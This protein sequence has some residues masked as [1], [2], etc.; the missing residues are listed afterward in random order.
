MQKPYSWRAALAVFSLALLSA[1]PFGIANAQGYV[2][3]EASVSVDDSELSFESPVVSAE[4][5]AEDESL[6]SAQQLLQKLGVDDSVA[7]SVSYDDNVLTIFAD[8]SIQELVR[9][10]LGSKVG[11]LA[12]QY[13]KSPFS[14]SELT[15]EGQ[16]I[17]SL[18][19]VAWAGP[20]D[21]FSGL[22]V[23]IRDESITRT[24]E[25]LSAYPLTLVP[26]PDPIVPAS[27]DRTG[28]PV[29]GGSLI[30][31]TSSR[32][33]CSSG[34]QIGFTG[35]GR[36]FTTAAHCRTG[37]WEGANGWNL[38]STN[39]TVSQTNDI[40]IINAS[41]FNGLMYVNAWNTNDA[42][43][44]YLTS[45]PTNNQRICTN[46]AITATRCGNNYV[47]GINQSLTY[48]GHT[49]TPGFWILS[50]NYANGAQVCNVMRGDSGSPAFT[51]VGT[52]SVEIRGFVVALDASFST[53]ECFDKNPNFPITFD[54]RPS[55]RAFAVNVQQ[56]LASINAYPIKA[57]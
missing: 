29:K 43:N 25:K 53:A 1:S 51:Y 22:D 16:R 14:V 10:T 4:E 13:A 33:T 47:R 35:G 38:G 52:Q 28:S 48:L 20:N 30:T 11:V 17:A 5:R 34:I 36:G 40:Q 15:L 42:K 45:N 8:A 12:V 7:S 32:E 9:S 55:A 18:N 39:G 49:R 31:H 57:G 54:N 46:G 44:V 6:S 24:G 19:G 41:S 27:R 56:A 3:D 26:A 21:D 50:Q 23:G 37:A 2:T